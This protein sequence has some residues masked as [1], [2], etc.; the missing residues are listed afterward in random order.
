MRKNLTVFLLCCFSLPAADAVLVGDASTSSSSPGSN[1]GTIGTIAVGGT[2]RGFLKFDLG[3]L[4]AGTTSD[5]VANAILRVYV[6]RVISPGTLEIAAVGGAW[7]EATITDSTAP[8]TTLLTGVPVSAA[9]QF[10][11]ADVTAEV[12]RWLD[13][14]PSNQGFALLAAP[15]T[16]TSIVLD[17]KENTV[18]SQPAHLT[19]NLVS[20]G[21]RG[22]QGNT[23]PQGQQGP[24]GQK[25]STGD[26]GPSTASGMFTRVSKYDILDGNTYLGAY[27]SCPAAYPNLVSGGCG[28]RDFNDAA[29]DISLRYNGPAIEGYQAWYCIFDNG[30]SHSRTITMQAICSK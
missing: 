30:S 12:K 22:P 27:L 19:I 4:P 16:G 21:P 5:N 8:G 28:H 20:M 2:S 3:T 17:S 23:G 7:S 6:N 25:G 14:P 1:S 18:T 26:A 13:I 29:L 11:Y 9:G 15:G 10:V 24:Q